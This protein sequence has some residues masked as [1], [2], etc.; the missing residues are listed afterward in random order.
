MGLGT[1]VT[2]ETLPLVEQGFAW[3]RSRVVGIGDTALDSATPCANWDLRQ[4]V[5]HAV[6]AATTAAGVLSGVDKVDPWSRSADEMADTDS[7]WPNPL[8]RYDETI[9]TIL[10]A[11]KN[12]A[13]QQL[14]LLQGAQMPGEMLARAATFDSV[15]HGWDIAKATGQDPTIPPEL[16][17][18]FIAFAAMI[19][20]DSEMRSLA[21]G[22]KLPADPSASPTDRL[23]ALLGRQS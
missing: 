20:E 18:T 17:E 14:F 7:G 22:P 10:D 12:G 13:C 1:F 11:V 15:V 5:N 2:M 6:N 4:L 23:V 3:A 9:A 8:V 21:F 19:P 16:A